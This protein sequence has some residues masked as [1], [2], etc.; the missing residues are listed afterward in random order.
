[1]LSREERMI[2][3]ENDTLGKQKI[4]V[5]SIMLTTNSFLMRVDDDI[6]IKEMLIFYF[7]KLT[8]EG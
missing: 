1:M 8:A 4:I 5:I 6:K 3:P 7:Q 2:S